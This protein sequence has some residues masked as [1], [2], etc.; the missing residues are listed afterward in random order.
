MPGAVVWQ[1]GNRDA[2]MLGHPP[3]GDAGKQ[4]CIS[5]RAGDRREE[6]CLPPLPPHPNLSSPVRPA[7]PAMGAR[8]AGSEHP[9]S[10]RLF[11]GNALLRLNT[12]PEPSGESS[13]CL[14]FTCLGVMVPPKINPPSFTRPLRGGTWAWSERG[15]EPK[16]R[17][18]GSGERGGRLEAK[19]KVG[20]RVQA[21][22]WWGHTGCGWGC[23]QPH[24][25][26]SALVGIPLTRGIFYRLSLAVGRGVKSQA[27]LEGLAWSV[28]ALRY[29]FP[30]G[31]LDELGLSLIRYDLLS[32]LKL[33]LSIFPR[34]SRERSWVRALPAW[35]RCPRSCRWVPAR[36]ESS[37][38]P[39]A[40]GLG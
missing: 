32:E 33:L 26:P 29:P 4:G 31:G 27:R 11:A 12:S 7:G 37:P 19:Y 9:G 17:G 39:G 35:G 38:V 10:S 30:R 5:Q 20:E 36:L 8:A 40:G 21:V 25:P 6:G 34:L 13:C 3:A 23:P 28:P 18:W 22:S 15:A 16:G 14:F 24:L 1:A 2:G